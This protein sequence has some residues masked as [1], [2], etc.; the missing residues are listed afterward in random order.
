MCIFI[1]LYKSLI[2]ISDCDVVNTTSAV[3]CFK[4]IV[5][6]TIIFKMTLKK[7]GEKKKTTKKI[8]KPKKSKVC[9]TIDET[10]N[11]TGDKNDTS[12]HS[13]ESSADQNPPGIFFYL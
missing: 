12:A 3:K 10:K 2:A 4:C 5:T 1:I 9:P 8:N 11:G 13:P 6:T 7:E